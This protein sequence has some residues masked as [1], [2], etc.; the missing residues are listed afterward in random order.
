MLSRNT[1]PNCFLIAV[2]TIKELESGQMS[3]RYNVGLGIA[4]WVSGYFGKR[5][6]FALLISS[7][8]GYKMA[9]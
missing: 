5:F 8:S 3:Q 2:N 4:N 9:L 7:E 1:I 6:P